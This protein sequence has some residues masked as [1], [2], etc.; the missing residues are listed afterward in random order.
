MTESV[1]IVQPGFLGDAVLATGLLRGLKSIS[2]SI[3]L[4]FLVR[5]EFG[6]LFVDHPAIDHLHLLDK[7]KKG[8]VD[9]LADEL[10]SI[11]Y[12]AALVP[13]RAFRSS[14]IPFK[15]RIP[16]RIGF[17]QSDFRLLLTQTV[18][19]DIT[20]REIDRNA[21]LAA[22]LGADIRIDERKGWLNPSRELCERMAELYT[23]GSATVVIAPGSVWETKRWPAVHFSTLIA[24]L[25]RS[26]YNVLLVG[27]PKE[28]PL[29]DGIA[30]DA[31]LPQSN[32]LAGQLSLAELAG[33]LAVADRIVTNDSAPLHIAESLGTPVTAMFG[34][35]V[36]EFGFAPY[37]ADSDLLERRGLP[38][39]PCG[40][41]GH[42]ACPI[43]THEC[44]EKI[45]PESVL[46]SICTRMET[47]GSR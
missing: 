42:R 25:Q 15:A 38:C 30:S 26:G 1:L 27:S 8:D 22:A 23:G 41:H 39:R 40:I 10:R 32:V 16:K 36:P 34:P 2:S 18:P 4:G 35:T 11:R 7:K 21:S 19:Y 12:Q 37:L 28:K 46:S 14:L 44:M 9:R 24:G 31:G 6:E 43:G 13:H 47:A 29:C 5:R 17:R 33:L 20:D 45:S 3:S